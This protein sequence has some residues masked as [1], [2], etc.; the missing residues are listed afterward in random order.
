MT[1]SFIKLI[2]EASLTAGIAA[3][4]VML[5]RI[6]LKKAPKRWSYLLWAVVFFRCLCPFS[7]E[8]AVSV[9]NA[10]PE[11]SVI[12]GS[13]T[14]SAE[15][16]QT[17]QQTDISE[18]L[19]YTENAPS[20]LPSMGTFYNPYG[21]YDEPRYAD[22]SG[23]AN[24][25]ENDHTENISEPVYYEPETAAVNTV[26]NT[27]TEKTVNVHTVLLIIWL[28]GVAAMAVYGTLSYARLMRKICT[29]VKTDDGVYETDLIPTAFSAG[30]FPPKVYIPCGLSE[31]EHRLIVTHER[32]HIRRCDHITKLLAF[33]ALAVHWFN[34][35][36]WAAFTLMTK[37]MELSC[38]E[39]VLKICGAEEKKDYS[40]A[41][42]RVSMKR[43]GLAVI[44][45]AFGETGIKGQR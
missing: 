29:A 19:Q 37:D 5:I 21:S 13:N 15:A 43:S 20:P 33:V 4:A 25:A 39:A 40:R 6:P 17:E 18:E 35:L 2:F 24:F 26:E 32:V 8:S 41:L 36:I 3:A 16:P 38:D 44:P 45:I 42:L 7:V 10:V 34:P 31:T 30:F 27:E 1:E 9:F 11:K 28:A 12:S 14:D 23:Y 22:Y